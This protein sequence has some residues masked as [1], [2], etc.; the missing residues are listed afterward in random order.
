MIMLQCA[1]ELPDRTLEPEYAS[2]PPAAAMATPA[3]ER[4]LNP[5]SASELPAI[6]EPQRVAPERDFFSPAVCRLIVTTSAIILP[7]KWDIFFGCD[8]PA[9]GARGSGG[10]LDF[11]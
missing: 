4:R 1:T 5:Q 11:S 10:P 8:P 6:S 3:G 7:F 9:A 2:N